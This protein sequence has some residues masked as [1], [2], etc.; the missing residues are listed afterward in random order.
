DRRGGAPDIRVVVHDP[1][2]GPIHLTGNDGTGLSELACHSEERLDALAEC[3]DIREPIIHLGVDVDRPLAFPGRT[4]PFVP[5][6]LQVRRLRARARARDEQIS[7]VLK[8]QS[9][10]RGIDSRAGVPYALVR[11]CRGRFRAAE[12]ERY[13]AKELRVVGNVPALRGLI[14]AHD[15]DVLA[16]DLGGIRREVIEAAGVRRDSDVSDHLTRTHD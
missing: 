4:R 10:E 3:S 15:S 11:R 2:A 14:V 6:A 8:V 5:D 1:T 7:A 13:T 12:I 9:G 16:C